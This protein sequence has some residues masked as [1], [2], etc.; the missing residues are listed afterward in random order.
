M[1]IVPIFLGISRTTHSIGSGTETRPPRRLDM[2]PRCPPSDHMPRQLCGATT[3]ATLSNRAGAVS[4]APR[5]APAGSAV[6]VS[7]ESSHSLA[8]PL[9]VRHFP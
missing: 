1:S 6:T 9:F 2:A 7:H 3:L 4:T 8:N 5:S